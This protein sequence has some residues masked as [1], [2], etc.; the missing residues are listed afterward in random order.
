MCEACQTFAGGA[1]S[2]PRLPVAATGGLDSREIIARILTVDDGVC[3]DSLLANTLDEE[4]LDGVLPCG[5]QA[6]FAW[7]DRLFRADRLYRTSGSA[8]PLAG[9]SVGLQAT[10]TLRV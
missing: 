4:P 7:R 8:S 6:H 9:A 10:V 2:Q 5:Q 1:G 3:P